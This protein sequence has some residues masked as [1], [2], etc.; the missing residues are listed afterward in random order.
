[1]TRRRMITHAYR[2][3][4]GWEEVERRDLTVESAAEL[5]QEGF[6]LVRARRGWRPAREISLTRYDTGGPRPSALP[7]PGR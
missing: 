4:G 3:P 1:M 2:M 5:R 7:T 6:T